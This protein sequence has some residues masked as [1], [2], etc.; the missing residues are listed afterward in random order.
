MTNHDSQITNG[1]VGRNEGGSVRKAFTGLAVVAVTGLIVVSVILLG[2]SESVAPPG[3]GS[4]GAR[5][6][7][8][9]TNSAGN[10]VT[11]VDAATHR[12]IGSIETGVTPHGL[13]AS[14]D[15][16]RIYITGETDHD[17]VAIETATPKVL[18]KALVG[19]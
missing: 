11:V 12:V 3:G 8:Y 16:R 2:R 19:D 15:G 4:S 13:V 7:F 17:V 1:I 14:P 5:E 9:V 6:I 18:W 10:D